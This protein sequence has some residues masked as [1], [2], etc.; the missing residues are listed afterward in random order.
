MNSVKE[1][2]TKQK[3]LLEIELNDY[4]SRHKQ[5]VRAINSH[6]YYKKMSIVYKLIKWSIG[7][8]DSSFKDIEKTTQTIQ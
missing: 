4:I 7:I 1:V 6:I 2:L 8:I 3:Q 5:G